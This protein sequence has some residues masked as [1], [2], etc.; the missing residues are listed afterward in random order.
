MET[1]VQCSNHAI[2]FATL[3]F[4]FVCDP[5]PLRAK[6]LVSKL[7]AAHLALIHSPRI[8]CRGKF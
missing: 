6:E 5:P 4:T 1:K 3:L 2:R 7:T 8:L